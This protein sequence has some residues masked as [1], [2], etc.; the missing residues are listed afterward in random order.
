MLPPALLFVSRILSKT[1]IVS[2]TEKARVVKSAVTNKI[3][4]GAL[5]KCPKSAN[6]PMSTTLSCTVAKIA[7]IPN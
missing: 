5:A 6:K 1:T 2:W 3:S 7:D 4:T